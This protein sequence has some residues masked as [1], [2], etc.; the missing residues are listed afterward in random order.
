[1]I[2]VSVFV[3]AM[4][5]LAQLVATGQRAATLGRLQT[6]AVLLAETKMSEILTGFEPMR[7]GSSQSFTEEAD[8]NWFWTLGVSST[9]DSLLLTLELT[10][11]HI[12][13]TGRVN[14]TYTLTRLVRDPGAIAEM[15]FAAE[16][17]AAEDDQ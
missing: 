16:E 7:S 11:Y 1:M 8:V 14:S 9:D 6:R 15:V 2:S 10:V 3:A 4:A 17:T 5:A 12:T 13:N